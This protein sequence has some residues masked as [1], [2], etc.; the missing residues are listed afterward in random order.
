MNCKECAE[1]LKKFDNYLILIHRNPDGDTVGSAAALCSALRRTGKTAFVRPSADVSEKLLPYIQP[2]FAPADY[3]P[4]YVIAVD[5]AA[6]GLLPEGFETIPLP[7]HFFDM[8][9]FRAPDGVVF[10]ADCLSSRK[11][12]EKYK[13]GVLYDVAA[14]LDT[15]E[16]VKQLQAP[17]FVPAHA[18]DDIFIPERRPHVQSI[19]ASE[20]LRQHCG[21]LAGN[22]PAE[23]E[24]FGTQHTAGGK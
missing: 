9:G 20:F 3:A 12:L 7:G 1:L 2:G 10:L 17:L 6:P 19:A 21:L 15:L 24:A 8:V 22:E 13:I 4:A 5:I 14:Y 16:R 18:E 23:A 11:T